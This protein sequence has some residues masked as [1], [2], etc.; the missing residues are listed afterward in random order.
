[1][2]FDM[3]EDRQMLSET[4]SRFLADRYDWETRN[5]VAYTAPYTDAGR[6]LA[7]AGLGIPGALVPEEQGGFG[8]TGFGRGG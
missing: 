5:R 7:L 2:N 8:G 3:T 4:L 1:M 6:W